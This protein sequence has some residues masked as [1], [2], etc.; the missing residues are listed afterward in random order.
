[1]KRFST[2]ADA[3]AQEDSFKSPEIS[4]R[5]LL[6]AAAGGV[7]G[8]AATSLFSGDAEARSLPDVR[9]LS[10]TN[11]HNGEK[12]SVTYHADGT[13]ISEA[14]SE[15]DRIM[16]DP[17]DNSV[18]RMDRRLY[19]LLFALHKKL[20]TAEPFMLISGY[21]SPKTNAILAA[22]SAGVAKRSYHMR[23]WAADVRLRSRSVAQIS[24]A[25]LSMQ[26]G[27]VGRYTRSNFV[28]VD[29]GPFRRWGV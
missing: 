24:N 10:F 4:R 6:S 3:G 1:M 23:G 25:A 13:Y 12:L 17:W 16:R 15:L 18:N 27:G 28:H 19:D 22:R 8:I 2:P 20:D 9:A 14:L 11:L 21:R 7:A 29:T 5:R 26:R